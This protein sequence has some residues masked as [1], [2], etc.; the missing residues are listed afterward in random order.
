VDPVRNPKSKIENPKSVRPPF[1]NKK[2]S[3]PKEFPMS[4][5]G[6]PTVLD[7][8]KIQVICSLIQVGISQRRAAAVVGVSE[9]VIRYWIHNDPQ[10]AQQVAQAEALLEVDLLVK[11]N[12]AASRSWRAATFALKYLVPDRFGQ[13]KWSLVDPDREAENER[14]VMQVDRERQ[15]EAAAKAGNPPPPDPQ[16]DPNDSTTAASRQFVEQLDKILADAR[17]AHHNGAASIQNPK[18]KIQNGLDAAIDDH[19]FRA[20][21]LATSHSESDPDQDLVRACKQWLRTSPKAAEALG[22]GKRQ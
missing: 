6:R 14:H 17:G 21:S 2:S 8:I 15:E 5:V 16:P 11:L 1:Q 18:S 10:F 19:L 9:G 7:P 3:I 4:H 13:K 22:N 20:S 12:Q